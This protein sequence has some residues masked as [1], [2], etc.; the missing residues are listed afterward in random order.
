MMD[1]DHNWVDAYFTK[2]IDIV[3]RRVFIDTDITEDSIG[4][5]IKGL[6]LMETQDKSKRI[7]VFISSFGGSIYESLALYDIFQTITCPIST[8]GYGKVMSSALIIIA[9]GDDGKRWVSPNVSF[10]HHDWYAEL[11]GTGREVT[12]TVKHYDQISKS[13]TKIL[14]KHSNK[15]AKWWN[16]KINLGRDFYFTGEQAIEWGIADNVWVEK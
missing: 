1:L 4:N 16:S 8:F 5:A 6:Y 12:N 3:N 9:G 14:E 13:W 15:D 11:E 2:G 7:E 10:M